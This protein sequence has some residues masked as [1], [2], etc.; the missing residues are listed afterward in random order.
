MRLEWRMLMRVMVPAGIY[1]CQQ[2]L[3]FVAPLA[4]GGARCSL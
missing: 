4:A 3:E 2:M 1:N